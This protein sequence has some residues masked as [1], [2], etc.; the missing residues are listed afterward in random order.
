MINFML[1]V[2]RQGKTRLTKWYESYSTK[3]KARIVREV[4]ARTGAGGRARAAGA[5]RAAT[6]AAEPPPGDD[7]G[8]MDVQEEGNGKG[9]RARPAAT[10]PV[11]GPRPSLVAPRL[12]RP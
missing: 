4:T 10:I 8:T 9:G 3:E 7:D 12:G 5:A 6:P 1:L 11:A 2:S